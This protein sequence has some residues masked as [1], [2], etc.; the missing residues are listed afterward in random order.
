M[1][2]IIIL[3]GIPGSGKG[4]QAKRLALR[5]GYTHISTG[6]LLRAFAN[7][8]T[9]SSEDREQLRRMKEG[10][11]VS[12]DLVYKL[13]F[14]AIEASLARGAG[15]VLDGAIRTPEQ[16]R[17]YATYFGA[18]GLVDE[19][20]ALEI[21]LTDEEGMD[22]ILKRRVCEACGSIVPFTGE[23]S[24]LVVC[25]KC[26]GNLIRRGDDTL[27]TVTERM[28]VQGNSSVAP[29]REYYQSENRYLSVDGTR[30]IDEVEQEILRALGE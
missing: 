1:K 5:Y 11:L 17:G 16:A 23:T 27:L 28:R 4:T 30:D 6:D 22:R 25:E 19:V 20:V 7:D 24:T 2:K 18:E 8:P 26:G 3:L 9:G 21:L 10:K 14:R 15:V 29:V 12:D 13:A